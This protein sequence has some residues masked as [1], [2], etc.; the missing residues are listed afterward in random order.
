MLE[1]AGGTGQFFFASKTLL[2]AQADF[3]NVV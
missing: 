3:L 1:N 2:A